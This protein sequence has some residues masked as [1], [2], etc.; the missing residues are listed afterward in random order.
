M[1]QLRR[2][3]AAGVVTMATVDAG[4]LR[5]VVT[6]FGVP[7]P[8]LIYGTAWKKERTAALVRQALS[9]G[10]RGVD[11]A[12]QP[13]H[14]DEAGVGAG[15]AAAI[16]EGLARSDIYLQTKFTPFK[17][18]D[19][20]NL[21]YDANA[22]LSEQVRQSFEA[23]LRNLRTDYL[24]CLVL[25]SPYP[26]DKDTAT[27][28]RAME[29]LHA[30]GGVRQ[31]GVSNCYEAWRFEALY[32]DAKVKPAVVQNRFYAKTNYDAELRAFCAK[33]GVY[34]QSFWTLTANPEVLAQA[35]LTDIAAKYGRTPAQ[36]FFRY[37]TQ[38]DISCL[39]GATSK[40]HMEQDLAIFDFR[41]T[42]TECA[43][44]GALLR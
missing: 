5:H 8:R 14:Y 44:I 6:A 30:R 33:N 19:P 25:H 29:K 40:D 21:P 12:C 26:E 10:F 20:D 11:T 13:K 34:Y 41:L 9:A 4:H 17:G 28:W 31:L 32:R 36:L 43:A 15:L 42:A 38:I 35:A 2:R 37:L 16:G 1:E 18:Q 39:I 22:S 23:S 7:M 27:V 24:D 3:R